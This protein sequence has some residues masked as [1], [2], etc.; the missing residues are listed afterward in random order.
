MFIG[1]K[2]IYLELLKTGCTYIRELLDSL[3]DG[4]LVDKHNLI[5]NVPADQ[6]ANLSSKVKVGNIRNPWDWYVS[7]WSF[8]CMSKGSLYHRLATLKHSSFYKK[9]PSAYLLT[10]EWKAVYTDS[11]DPKLF[12]KWL[13]MIFDKKKNMKLPGFSSCP[14]SDFA[15]LM[16]FNYLRLYTWDFHNYWKSIKDIELLKKADKEKN[17]IDFFIKMENLDQDFIE[18]MK[19]IGMSDQ[20][21]ESMVKPLLGKKVNESKRKD[22]H[23][24]YNDESM[25]LV[26]ER[27]KYIL[28]KHGYS[29]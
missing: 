16:T 8:G 10:R 14:I 24:Y 13:K 20:E 1:P 17:F 11:S 7:L 19:K 21:I 26:A 22:Y 18:L 15:G 6:T 4:E 27:E 29:Y 28:E 9:T 23:F 12:Q 2:I 3:V 5:K 25:N